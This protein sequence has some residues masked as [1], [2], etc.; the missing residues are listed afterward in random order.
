MHACRHLWP[1]YH[2][3]AATGPGMP[4]GTYL[5]SGRLHRDHQRLGGSARV[6]GLHGIQVE[7]DVAVHGRDDRTARGAGAI[8]EFDDVPGRDV[9][10]TDR[11]V[12]F[13]R[14]IGTSRE[15]VG[16]RDRGEIEPFDGIGERIGHDEAA[17]AGPCR[18]RRT[19][20]PCPAP[21][22]VSGRVIRIVPDRQR[23]YGAI[24]NHLAPSRRGRC[25]RDRCRETGS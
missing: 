14:A 10:V 19:W 6:L 20:S 8:L 11:V 16:T 5:Q 2:P 9:D 3:P 24:G 22:P 13:V 1:R 15:G 17:G 25:T 23:I 7:G 4:C 18:V 12:R 21:L